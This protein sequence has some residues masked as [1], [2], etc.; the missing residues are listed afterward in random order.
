MRDG[1]TRKLQQSA[2]AVGFGHFLKKFRPS[3]VALSGS[4]EG[5]E[6]VIDQRRLTLGRGPGVDMAFENP[7]MSREH[8]VLEFSSEGFRISD[9]ESTNGVEVNGSLVTAAN[10]SHGDRFSLGDQTFQ[11]VLEEREASPKIYV[12]DED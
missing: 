3:I 9:H 1:Q 7:S 4:A 8:A 11:L 10:L 12:L 2:D 5:T 6:I